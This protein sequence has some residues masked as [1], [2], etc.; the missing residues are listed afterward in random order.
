MAQLFK[1]HIVDDGSYPMP[2]PSSSITGGPAR[3]THDAHAE[4][5]P[6][7]VQAAA[8]DLEKIVQ[9][10]QS[11]RPAVEGVSEALRAGAQQQGYS[12][13]LTRAQ[14]EVQHTTMEAMAALTAAQHERY[15]LAAQHEPALADLA[16]RIARKVIGEHL[17][18]DP[19]LVARIV[20]E[21]IA[22]LEPS[23]SLE[24]RV[25]P[26]DLAA[27]ESSRA[28]LERLVTGAGSV[29]ITADATVDR[30]GVVL[31]SPVGEVDA[32][33]STKLSVLETAFAAQRREL[34]G[35]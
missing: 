26:D 28:S 11:L 20:H 8:G 25:H 22:E 34:T 30:G 27:V 23:V 24:V 6:A 29:R 32:R 3:D 15:A 17:V 2:Q 4:V 16:L 13:G 9:M 18:A 5:H 14:A 12:E 33:I 10:V 31:V 35:S 7:Q 1:G 19:A 21:T